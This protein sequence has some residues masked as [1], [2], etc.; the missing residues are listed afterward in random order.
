MPVW[1]VYIVSQGYTV[2]P[3]GQKKKKEEEKMRK[4]KEGRRKGGEGEDRRKE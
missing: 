1:L 2:R 4:E 3:T